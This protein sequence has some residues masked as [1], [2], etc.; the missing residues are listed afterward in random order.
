MSRQVGVSGQVYCFEP[1]SQLA[2]ELR[3]IRDG[4][5]MPNIIVEEL[6]LSSTEGERLLIVPGSCPSPGATLESGLVT[7]DQELFKTPT[8]TLD[9]YVAKKGL[10]RVR[11]I[12]CDVE[13]HELD[14][15]LGGQ[16]TLSDLKP[17]LLFECEER[18]HRRSSMSDVFAFLTSK[19]YEGF[20]FDGAGKR[21]IAEFDPN[22]HGKFGGER[23]VNNFVF[24]PR[25]A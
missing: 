15:F 18:H 1:Q 11:F 21:P 7:G 13:G 19:G 17:L 23:Y 10:D 25:G 24:E 22:L 5:P 12:K 3:K 14:V 20:F 9:S 4:W 2:E 8:T 6:A 16:K